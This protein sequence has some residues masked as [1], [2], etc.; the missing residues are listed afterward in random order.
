VPP[1]STTPLASSTAPRFEKEAAE[2]NTR[3]FKYAW[4]LDKLAVKHKRGITIDIP[5][6]VSDDE[7]L[8]RDRRPRA[9]RLHLE[10]DHGDVAGRLRG[11]DHRLDYGR[12]RGR[13]LEGRTDA[14]A[15]ADG[16]TLRVKVKQMI[17]YYNKIDAM[18]PKYGKAWY[19]EMMKEVSAYLKKL[20]TTR[21]RFRPCRSPG[22]RGTTWSRGQ[23][24][25]DWYKGSTLL[26]ALGK[27]SEPKRPLNGSMSI[28]QIMSHNL[29][30]LHVHKVTIKRPQQY[31]D[32]VYQGGHIIF[33]WLIQA[34][35]WGGRD[36]N[37]LCGSDLPLQ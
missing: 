16:F 6:E 22:S 28:K 29:L 1:P 27:V 33:A 19:E 20:G 25:L 12:I 4:V 23:A 3:S 37:S 9:S 8:H 26:E 35:K 11:A 32:K 5:L 14:R 18:T 15:R 30:R 31:N 13:D 36:V 10:H 21:T 24:I 2:T 34:R 7:V 17:C